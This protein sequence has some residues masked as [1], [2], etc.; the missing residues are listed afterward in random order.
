MRGTERPISANDTTHLPGPKEEACSQPKPV[1]SVS[2]N[3][4]FTQQVIMSMKKKFLKFSSVSWLLLPYFRVK[5]SIRW[6]R[7]C[8][9]FVPPG[10]P[11]GSKRNP[12]KY[13]HIPI[14]EMVSVSPHPNNV[15][16]TQVGTKLRECLFTLMLAMCRIPVILDRHSGG[17]GLCGAQVLQGF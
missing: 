7:S 10:L 13:H 12:S 8:S 4:M 9:S 3:S 11:E 5:P 17:I 16:L 15:L 1:P 14:L 2:L 6:Y